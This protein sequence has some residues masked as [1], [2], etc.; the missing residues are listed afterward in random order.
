MNFRD[1]P[2][3]GE[4]LQ[5]QQTV[6]F[7]HARGAN[8]LSFETY[9][10]TSFRLPVFSLRRV[11]NNKL[12]YSVYSLQL[13]ITPIIHYKDNKGDLEVSRR[14]LKNYFWTKI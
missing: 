3:C 6:Q 2:N 9:E 10:K 5:I 1:S 13:H 12:R 8:I 11:N 14:R 4:E 7:K